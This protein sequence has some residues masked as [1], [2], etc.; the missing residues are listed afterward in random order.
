[1]ES[2]SMRRI[3]VEDL[4]KSV[5]VLL[6]HI[7]E[8][9]VESIDLEKQY[10]WQVNAQNKYD[11]AT[12]PVGLVVGDLWDDLDFTEAVLTK[13]RKEAVAYTLTEV[14]QVLAYLGEVTGA[15]LASRGA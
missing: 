14:A 7:L 4:R 12:E 8:S 5:N 15:R 10:Y 9:G 13:D 1:M 11:M 2:N 3:N 6:D